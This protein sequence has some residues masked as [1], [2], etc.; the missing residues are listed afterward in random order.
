MDKRYQVFISSTYADLKNERQAI[1]QTLME[2]D[3]IP[4]GMELFPA[5]DEEQLQFIQKIIDDC[6]YYLLLIGGR[7]GSTTLEGISYTEKEYDYAVKKGIKIIAMLHE[8]PGVIAASKTERD[9]K[10]AK[11]LELFRAKAATGRLVKYWSDA[12]QLPG[13]VSLS[14]TKT[15]KT[16]PAVGWVRGDTT[17]SADLL[18][19]INELR[20][21]NEQLRVKSPAQSNVARSIPNLA[22]LADELLV[23]G[24]YVDEFNRE[25]PFEHSFSWSEIFWHISPY[26]DAEL[27]DE[28]L[29]RN[30]EASIQ[31][32]L[33]IVAAS[34][35]IW[36]QSFQTIGIQ[37]RA[38]GLAEISR[39]D[40]RSIGRR[41][42]LTSAGEDLM[43]EVRTAKDDS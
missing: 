9:P 20:K 8:N 43:F 10:L 34:L 11:K 23:G 36:D 31:S 38:L 22:S 16:Y 5:T 27:T 33:G 2:M 40:S 35:S 13:L 30:F 26:L 6:D 17:A 18:N 25:V 4:A 37:I 41:W 39:S 1:M 21:D 15:I 19:Q 29:R 3:C 14:L 24:F 32:S 28:Q 42:K 12:N 7:Y